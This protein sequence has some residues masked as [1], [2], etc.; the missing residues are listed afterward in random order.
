MSAFPPPPPA[1]TKLGL[2]RI[3]SPNAG[4][5][6]APL[7]LGGASI[8]D[9][10]EKKGM[11]AMNKESSIKLLDAYFDAGVSVYSV[12]IVTRDTYIC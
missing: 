8:G 4:I 2:Y 11:G 3:L 12:V 9:R 7:H 5:Y 1:Q 10:W 6:V